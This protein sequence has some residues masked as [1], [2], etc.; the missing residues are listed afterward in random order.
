MI[1]FN[2]E[3]L[4][5]G[6]PRDPKRY[7]GIIRGLYRAPL[8]DYIGVIL[9]NAQLAPYWDTISHHGFMFLIGCKLWKNC[10]EKGE[11]I[12]GLGARTEIVELNHFP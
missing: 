2:W 12:K 6:G 8:R 4:K 3:F 7:R 11:R 10:R 5:K 1:P 9:R